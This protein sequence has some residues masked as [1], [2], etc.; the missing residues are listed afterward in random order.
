M[1]CRSGAS[2]PACIG[3]RLV[4]YW[5]DPWKKRTQILF[6][7]GRW[8]VPRSSTS[9]SGQLKGPQVVWCKK[10]MYFIYPGETDQLIK[11]YTGING[12]PAIFKHYKICIKLGDPHMRA[13]PVFAL[14]LCRGLAWDCGSRH[15]G[16]VLVVQ[17]RAERRH[18]QLPSMTRYAWS[19]PS[20]ILSILFFRIF[21]V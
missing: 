10:T 12:W 14:W 7:Y 3:T 9:F 20:C 2:T 16:V 1:C 17:N 13:L 5:M 15:T 8:H 11:K 4:K 6:C 19:F 18:N 21:L